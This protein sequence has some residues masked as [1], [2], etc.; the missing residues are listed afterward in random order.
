[1]GICV[2]V[3]IC[4]QTSMRSHRLGVGDQNQVSHSLLFPVGSEFGKGNARLYP[5]SRAGGRPEARREIRKK[6][7]HTTCAQQIHR[8]WQSCSTNVQKTTNTRSQ[9]L[10]RCLHLVIFFVAGA[11]ERLG[12]STNVQKTTNTR[13]Q[14]LPRCLQLFIFFVA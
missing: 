13:C 12:C 7:T 10:P 9:V 3:G 6:H 1:M 14:V 4:V 11:F 2:L 5:A 8:Q